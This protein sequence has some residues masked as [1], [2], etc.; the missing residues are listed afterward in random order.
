MKDEENEKS[1]AHYRRENDM[2][3]CGVVPCSLRGPLRLVAGLSLF[4]VWAV[5]VP[6]AAHA[7][8]PVTGN[9]AA[10]APSPKV[11]VV[12]PMNEASKQPLSLPATLNAD[13]RVL[14]CA[15][16]PGYVVKLTV[17]KG[18]SVKKGQLV[19]EISVPEMGPEL[20]LAKAKAVAAQAHLGKAQASVQVETATHHRLATLQSAEP[21]A[22]TQ[23]DVDVAEAKEK[24]ARAE[25]EATR[26]EIG[27]ANAEVGRLEALMRYLQITAPFDGTVTQRFVDEGAFVA[28]GSGSANALVEIARTARLRLACDLPERM[29][30]FVKQGHALRYSLAALPGKVFDGVVAR[31][32]ES[33]TEDSHT[34]LLE[35]DVDNAGLQ[36]SPGMYGA[37]QIPIEHVP[38]INRLPSSSLR[39]ID[40]KPCVFA[41]ESGKLRKILVEP[42]VNEGASVFVSGELGPE[43]LVVSGGPTSLAEGQQVE[44]AKGG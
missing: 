8:A 24:T 21:G 40:G 29:V 27:V 42:L 34:M 14:L 44:V 32:T 11:V 13:E 17:D 5:A 10:P 33:L 4:A 16:L 39:T 43:T 3:L 22:V 15:K 6:P 12:T 18:D 2:K 9:T 1:S 19:A 37:V 38:G 41:V 30:P 20:A 31:R 35:I 28:P 26:A 7:Q 36:F 25:A 23:E